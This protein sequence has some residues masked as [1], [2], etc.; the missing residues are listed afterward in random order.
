MP[1]V[2]AIIQAR[3]GSS[4][5]HGKVMKDLFG[6]PVLSHDIERIKQASAI[7]EIV[8]ATTLSDEDDI[9]V[10][11][12][13]KDGVKIYRGSENNVLSRYYQAGMEFSA[14]VVVRITSDCPLID[15]NIADEVINFYL[16]NDYDLV[17]NAGLY[18]ENRTYPRGLDLEVF[19]IKS[20]KEAYENAKKDYQLEHVTPYIY[21]NSDKIFYYKNSKDESKHRWTLDTEEDFELIKAIYGDL[22]KGVHNFYLDDILNLFNKKPELFYINSHI[23]QKK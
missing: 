2:V 9:I 21:E 10:R 12:A 11:Q 14:D 8:V 1:K 16:N 6:K 19:S 3:M 23:E 18:V 7:D 22:Y 20:L 15:P 5:L 4:R 17:T 13:F